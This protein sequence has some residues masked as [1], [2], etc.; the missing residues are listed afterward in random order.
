[1][2]SDSQKSNKEQQNA[3]K[4]DYFKNNKIKKSQSTS[5]SIFGATILE[6]KKTEDNESNFID[7]RSSSIH[8]IMKQE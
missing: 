2:N 5:K 8:K 7:S 3:C 6:Q 4:F 1:M